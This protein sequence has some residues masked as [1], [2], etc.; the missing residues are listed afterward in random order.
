[1]NDDDLVIVD[2]SNIIEIEIECSDVTKVLQYSNS[3][4]DLIIVKGTLDSVLCSSGA[5]KRVKRY[6]KRVLTNY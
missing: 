3:S 4:I 6:D 1:M 5:L 2:K